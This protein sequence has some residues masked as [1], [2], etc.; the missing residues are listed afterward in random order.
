MFNIPDKEREILKFWAEHK[1]FEKSVDKKAP[2][3]VFY[4]GPPF[5]TGTPHYGHIVASIMKDVVPRYWTMRGFRVERRWGWDCH[6]LPIE[7]I[8]EAEMGIKRK[9]EIEEIG[10]DKF[11]E[12][13]RSKVLV[14]A[15]EWRKV[16]ERLGRWVDMDNDYK[17][18]DKDYMES[19]WWVFKELWDKGYIYESYKSMHICPRCETTLSQS[20]I[21]EGYKDIEDVSVVAKFELVNEPGTF[22]LAWT[23]TPWTLPGNVAL[24]IGEHVDYIRV[25]SEGA[26]YILAK[27]N[28]EKIFSGREYKVL[29]EVKAEELVGLKYQ[30]LFN[31]YQNTNLENKENLY[32]IQSADFVTV[33]DGTGVVHIAPAFGEDDMNLGRDKKLPFIQHV[34]YDGTLRPE[35][36]DLYGLEVKPK[37][38]HTSTDQKIVDFLANKGLVFTTENFIHSYPHCWRCDSPLLNYA[39]SSYFVDVTKIKPQALETA[40]N[41]NWTPAH[42]KEGRF[43]NWLEGAKDWSISRQRFWGSVIPIWVCEKCSDK[44]VMGSIR[45]LEELSGEHIEDLHKHIM[46]QIKFPC[47]CGGIMK[48]IP[49]VLDCWF[50][51]GSMPYAQL[52]Y[53]FEN[54]EQFEANFPAQFIAEGADQTRAWFYYM[55]IL[56]NALKETNAFRNVIVNGIVLAEDGKKM[57]KKLRNYPDP[58]EVMEKYGADAVRYYLATAPVMKAD[59][60]CFSERGVDEV[61]KKVI[62]ILLNVFSFYQMYAKQE[63]NNTKIQEHKKEELKNILDRWIVAKLETL[64]RDIAKAY[65]EYDL[66]RASRPLGEF[67]DELSTWYLRRSRERFKGENETDKNDALDTLRYVLLTLSKLMAPVTPFIAE[68]LY[69][70]LKGDKE[71]VHL[72]TWPIANE[73]LIDQKV[74]DQMASVRQ[75]VEMGLAKRAEAGIKIR[76]PLAKLKTQS[77]KLKIEKEYLDLIKDELNVKKVEQ[78]DGEGELAV[79]LDTTITDELK[80]E[81]I[82]RELVRTINNIR[83]DM[84]LTIGD[85]VKINYS[86]HNQ[87]LNKVLEKYSEELKKSTLA[88][89]LEKSSEQLETFKINDLEIGLKI[90]KI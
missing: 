69:Q 16:I 79:E 81:G 72:E 25:E 6:G 9:K 24:A 11:N 39:T 56:A 52:H 4:D 83:K 73:K 42:I 22:V 55:H 66:V 34:A 65:D 86:N 77:T 44:K 59:D 23:T 45:E 50:E 29:N 1:I 71:S 75:V 38:D 8:V 15:D 37:N 88:D 12:S 18:M 5:A 84:K 54:K 10:V 33:E 7:N 47:S 31:Y 32:T 87:L 70:E 53:P 82:V 74:L 3:Y 90:E 62:M 36:K 63:S 89:S 85:R 41:I 67:I 80:E 20:E 21:T 40:K 58:M 35:V 64:K 17:T 61:V 68:H 48:R 26:K 46:D 28:L 30:P 27:N 78:I 13:C 76:Q 57:S 51:S 43:G 14:Y 2:D 19:I 49:D 60:L